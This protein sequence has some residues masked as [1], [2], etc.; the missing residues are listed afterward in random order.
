MT[1]SRTIEA[2]EWLIRV[3]EQEYVAGDLETVK[4]W[5]D[6]GRVPPTALVFHASLAEGTSVAQVIGQPVP[7]PK[8]RSNAYALVLIPVVL[9]GGCFACTLTVGTVGLVQEARV[10][11][12]L[13]AE[14]QHAEAELRAK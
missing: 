6:G 8:R 13:P 3:G 4:Q 7:M 11:Q 14:F 10:K 12:K 2:H 1:Q 9:I 5:V